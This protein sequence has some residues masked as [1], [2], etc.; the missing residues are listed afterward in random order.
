[1]IDFLFVIPII[2]LCIA[3]IIQGRRINYLH[4]TLNEMRT[5]LLF[6]Y[7]T[8]KRVSKDI[9]W[10]SYTIEIKTLSRVLDYI[11]PM[12][13]RIKKLEKQNDQL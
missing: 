6:E 1:M 12:S 9:E 10:S 7:A 13:Q 4:K 2:L 8:Q 11:L 5:E 3:I